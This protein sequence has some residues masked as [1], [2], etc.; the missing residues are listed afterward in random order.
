[1]AEREEVNQLFLSNPDFY[2]IN[3]FRNEEWKAG[4]LSKR[5]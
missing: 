3:W 1:L 4:Q 2:K 5:V